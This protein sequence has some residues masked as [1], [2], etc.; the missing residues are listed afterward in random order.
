MGAFPPKQGRAPRRVR[1]PRALNLGMPQPV[2]VIHCTDQVGFFKT[3][4]GFQNQGWI[5]RKR[6][7]PTQ[8]MNER[9]TELD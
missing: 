7:A 9:M 6:V 5:S 8:N 3:R 1:A 2:G 4:K